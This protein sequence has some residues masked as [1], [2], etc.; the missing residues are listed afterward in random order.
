M[1]QKKTL[2]LAYE[3]KAKKVKNRKTT[4]MKLSFIGLTSIQNLNI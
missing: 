2:S 1:A 4:I 3:T